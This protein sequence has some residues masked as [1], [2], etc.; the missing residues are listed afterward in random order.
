M[1]RDKNGR[2][3]RFAMTHRDITEK[4]LSDLEADKQRRLLGFIN[5]AQNLFL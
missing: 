5:H 1:T 2:A 4:K 3:E